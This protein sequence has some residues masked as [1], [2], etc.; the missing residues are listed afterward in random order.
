MF[1]LSRIPLM[2]FVGGVAV[3]TLVALIHHLGANAGRYEV[4]QEFDAYKAQ[5]H[6]LL[7]KARERTADLERRADAATVAIQKDT[8]R[9]YKAIDS[10]RRAGL[11]R[12]RNH[13]DSGGIKLPEP[14]ATCVAADA[15]PGLASGNGTT[16]WLI[17]YAA[18]AA[19]LQA[20]LDACAA[21]YEAVRE[22]MQ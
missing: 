7:D 22:V 14:A 21:Q 16:A 17:D 15:E 9:A 13:P 2:F 4:Q 3:L 8:D 5:Q 18:D 10:R 11:D 12:L 6:A 19:K 20:A 1:A